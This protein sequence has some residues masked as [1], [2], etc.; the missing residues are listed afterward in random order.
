MKDPSLYVLQDEAKAAR[1]GYGPTSRPCRRGNGAQANTT[2]TSITLLKHVFE[3]SPPSSPI[4]FRPYS[5]YA[6]GRIDA[7]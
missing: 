4:Q 3:H 6:R 1:R 2:E 7:H 5:C